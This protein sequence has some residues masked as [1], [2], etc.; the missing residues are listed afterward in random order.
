MSN[1]VCKTHTP[2]Y[3]SN[4]IWLLKLLL[5]SK[6]KLSDMQSYN[7][8]FYHTQTIKG[9]TMHLVGYDYPAGPNNPNV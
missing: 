1:V 2:S 4:A 6:N 7:H 5:D 9:E 3:P 8:V